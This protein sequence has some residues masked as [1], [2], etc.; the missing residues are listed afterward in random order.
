MRF[1]LTWIVLAGFWIGLSGYFDAIHLTWGFVAVTLVSA[2]SV[3]APRDASDPVGRELV[4]TVR[5]FGY[6][7]W[8]LGQIVVANWDVALRVLGIRPVDPRLIRFQPH[9]DSDYGR[10]ALANS[11][12]LTPGTVTVEIEE[13]G[14]FLVHAIAP[15]AADGLLEGSMVERVHR[16]EGS[17]A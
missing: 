6:V 17:S 1:V 10:V 3:R 11:I 16:V 7:P 5:L 14:A 13:D 12:T 9:L 2:I 4:R 8:L 15:T